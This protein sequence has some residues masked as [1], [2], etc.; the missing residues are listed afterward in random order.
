VERWERRAKKLAKRREQMQMS[1][2]G[3]KK[4]LLPLFLRRAE[5]AERG[6]KSSG[7]R[8]RSIRPP[9]AQT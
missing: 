8:K 7:K 3:L 2:A 4:V 1:G 6:E 5:E 9:R